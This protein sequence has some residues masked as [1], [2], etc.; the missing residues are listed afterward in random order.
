MCGHFFST[1]S[2]ARL[3]RSAF[4]T[5]DATA[6]P[7]AAPSVVAF[8]SSPGT[9]SPWSRSKV[10]SVSSYTSAISPVRHSSASWSVPRG[11]CKFHFVFAVLRSEPFVLGPLL[12]VCSWF[13]SASGMSTSSVV[14]LSLFSPFSRISS[15]SKSSCSSSSNTFFSSAAY[16]SAARCGASRLNCATVV[17]SD[18][19]CA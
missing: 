3:A 16:I 11:T 8:V 7:S 17:V 6:F 5:V 4:P 14:C 9:A 12:E 13:W 19:N 1:T 18:S 2:T 15:S 10:R